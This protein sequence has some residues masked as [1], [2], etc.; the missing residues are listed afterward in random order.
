MKNIHNFDILKDKDIYSLLLFILYKIKDLPEYSVLSELSYILDK[1][2]LFKFLKYYEGLTI[3]IPRIKDLIHILDVLLLYQKV[4]FEKLDF[5]LVLTQYDLKEDEKLKL[6][7]T[8]QKV[9][10]I[11]EN[12]V[13]NS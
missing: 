11:M 6:M 3:T 8:Y 4:N 13:I 1:D 12:Y 9:E 5:N 2:T 7:E 10:K